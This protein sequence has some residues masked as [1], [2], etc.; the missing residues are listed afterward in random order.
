[1]IDPRR[2]PVPTRVSSLVLFF[3]LPV[4]V[5]RTPT[6]I[7]GAQKTEWCNRVPEL[8]ATDS[9]MEVPARP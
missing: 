8:Y 3:L 2:D 9:I 1:M 6:F 5:L 7:D 4:P